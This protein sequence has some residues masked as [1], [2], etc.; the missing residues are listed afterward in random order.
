MRKHN[1]T[2]SI[3]DI[4]ALF[5]IMGRTMCTTLA[6]EG[7]NTAGK[8][9]YSFATEAPIIGSSLMQRWKSN[10]H[11]A[12]GATHKP[13]KRP[14]QPQQPTGKTAS[15]FATRSQLLFMAPAGFSLAASCAL[16]ALIY[17]IVAGGYGEDDKLGSYDRSL[18]P[19]L[20]EGTKT[21]A[22]HQEKKADVQLPQEQSANAEAVGETAQ[23]VTSETVV[24]KVASPTGPGQGF[25]SEASEA[26]KLAQA[27]LAAKADVVDS[28]VEANTK[29]DSRKPSVAKAT[30]KR[31]DLAHAMAAKAKP[32]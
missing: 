11:P 7:V 5:V 15:L 30:K 29:Q 2:F 28:N 3:S 1:E 18:P 10:V 14:S 20:G 4:L 32:S 22:K 25:D 6:H 27:M 12:Q 16:L 19:S 26:L 31:S 17:C 24:A 13:P 23:A 9:V 21:A 8:T